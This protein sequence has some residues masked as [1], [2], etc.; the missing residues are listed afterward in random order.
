MLTKKRNICVF[1]PMNNNCPTISSSSC[2]S[3]AF[4]TDTTTF[5]RTFCNEAFIQS[6]HLQT[7]ITTTNASITTTTS[8]VAAVASATAITVVV[9]I[10]IQER[11]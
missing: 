11:L 9:I 10:N 2:G 5:K 4:T 7:H 3:N 1:V 8:T 6:H